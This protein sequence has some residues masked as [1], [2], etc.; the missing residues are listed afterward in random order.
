M[1]LHIDVAP[2]LSTSWEVFL[3]SSPHPL[4]P[5][6]RTILT[7]QFSPEEREL[8]EKVVRPTVESGK[9]MTT[10]RTAYLTSSK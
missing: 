2:S 10:E 4:A 9:S 7:E 6:L 3:G 5:S 8:F 1:Q